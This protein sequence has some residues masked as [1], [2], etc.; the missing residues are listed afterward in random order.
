MYLFK[1]VSEQKIQNFSQTFLR[2]GYWNR[3]GNTVSL[4]DG[5]SVNFRVYLRMAVKKGRP[6]VFVKPPWE[7]N[8]HILRSK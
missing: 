1:N 2:E 3:L 6:V 5:Q 8:T 7:K 4:D